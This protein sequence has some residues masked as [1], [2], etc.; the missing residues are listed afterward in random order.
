MS[1]EYSVTL[2]DVSI[3]CGTLLQ[4]A[5]DF[6]KALAK[7]TSYAY[8]LSTSKFDYIISLCRGSMF[9]LANTNIL[10]PLIV[11]FTLEQV[12]LDSLVSYYRGIVTHFQ[13]QGMSEADL[14]SKLLTLM[15]SKE[16]RV[17]TLESTEV[18]E[19]PREA[20]KFISTWFNAED[21]AS[22]RDELLGV[23]RFIFLLVILLMDAFRFEL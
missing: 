3:L 12:A 16:I 13:Q 17:T 22:G 21:T 8:L 4:V 9:P 11:G 14:A 5:H 1:S 7:I 15:R 19:E 20:T 2:T 10:A 6:Y 18:Y 23:C